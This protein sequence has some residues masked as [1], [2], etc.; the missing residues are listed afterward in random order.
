MPSTL[1]GIVPFAAPLFAAVMFCSWN[2]AEAA[3]PQAGVQQA[4]AP[5]K[6]SPVTHSVFIPVDA[7]QQPTQG[8]YFLPE[9]FYAELYRRAALQAEKPQGWMIASAVYRAALAEDAAQAGYVVDRLTVEFEIRIFNAAARVRIPLRREE[10][11][12]EPGQAQLDDRAVQ[13]EW[14]PDGSALLL[15]I[16]RPGRISPGTHAPPDGAT[17]QPSRRFRS[18]DPPRP[19]GAA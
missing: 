9:P 19:H 15:E 8:K 13:P 14:E 18:G 12:L 10:V 7:K 3:D 6:L 2:L 5:A 11:S 17:R 16:A 1:T 4:G